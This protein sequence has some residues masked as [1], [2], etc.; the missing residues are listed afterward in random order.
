MLEGHFAGFTASLL[1][2]YLILTTV[3][4]T[5]S[6]QLVE[7]EVDLTQ[8]WLPQL[9]DLGLYHFPL[10]PQASNQSSNRGHACDVIGMQF[11]H[12]Y[13]YVLPP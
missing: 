12:T 1:P 5:A 2:M 7:L 9:Q 4:E 13:V 8:D 6:E 10:L 3:L 11:P